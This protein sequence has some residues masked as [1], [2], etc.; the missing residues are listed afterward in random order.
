MAALLLLVAGS[1][2]VPATAAHA[3]Q[4]LTGLEYI[5]DTSPSDTDWVK[6]AD[7]TC[8]YG[9]SVVGMG[10]ST[11]PAR[12]ELRLN[13]LYPSTQRTVLAQVAADDFYDWSWSVTVYAMCADTPPGWELRLDTSTTTS[14]ADRIV[15]VECS[16]GAKKPL[17]VGAWESNG[18]GEVI[19][20]DIN[21]SLTG[22]YAR[23]HEYEA[24]TTDQWWLR[25]YLIC[26]D[27][28]TGWSMYS[29]SNQTAYPTTSEYTGCESG[30]T[31]ISAGFDLDGS[32]GQIIPSS[33]RT[34]AYMASQSGMTSAREDVTGAPD[35]WELTVDVICVDP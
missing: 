20:S 10:W 28:P 22:A 26:A 6:M 34:V 19:I 18:H 30:R 4:P 7:V 13:M 3:A 9:K 12:S 21:P 14:D 35:T 31:A 1:L 32:A 5:S 11:N 8:P 17:A 2:I 29:S 33:M 23:A 27:P 16:S 24:G 15:D 25:V